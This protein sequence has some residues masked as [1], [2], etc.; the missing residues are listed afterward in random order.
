ML[1]LDS[2]QGEIS[3]FP[4][5]KTDSINLDKNLADTK[6]IFSS[7]CQAIDCASSY[8]GIE[9]DSLEL[10]Y[11]ALAFLVEAFKQ[12][13]P[14]Q[15][16]DSLKELH[17]KLLDK[18]NAPQPN[19]NEIN[20]TLAQ[21]IDNLYKKALVFHLLKAQTDGNE[22]K[23]NNLRRSL[24]LYEQVENNNRRIHQAGRLFT[25]GGIRDDFVPRWYKSR[26]LP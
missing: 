16:K 9:K 23:K 14:K 13:N 20:W 2:S 17:V 22:K 6:S 8:S 3:Y 12:L 24:K 25:F 15:W 10:E 4:L 26:L 7:L 19:L 5:E 1:P 18:A 11:K 21:L